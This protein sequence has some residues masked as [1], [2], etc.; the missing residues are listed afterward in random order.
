MGETDDKICNNALLHTK[1]APPRS[2]NMCIPM[3]YLDM[4]CVS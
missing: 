1:L 2:M 3:V 4:L